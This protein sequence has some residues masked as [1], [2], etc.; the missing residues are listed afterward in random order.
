MAKAARE[1][2]VTPPAVTIQ[3][4]LLEQT[5][6]LPLIERAGERTMQTAAGEKILS[7]ARRIDIILNECAQE[8]GQLKG[9][10]GGRISV[11]VVSTAK[12][13]AP[14]ALAAFRQK[15]N[16]VDV[17]LAVQNRH[18]TLRALESLDIDMAIMGRPPDT[19]N[20]ESEALGAHPHVI[21]ASPEHPLAKTPLTIDG[22][23][24]E[25][26]FVR[27]SGSGTRTVMERFFER[28]GFVPNVG[29][30]IGS[31]ETIK[32]AVIAGLG[33]AF[34]SAHT[35]AAEIAD[36]RLVPLQVEGLPVVRQWFVVR[37]VE[38]KAMP[39]GEAMWQFL[40]K[41]GWRFLPGTLADA[42]SRM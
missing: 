18:A 21:I 1:L 3:L 19:L 35:V 24:N 12:Y 13:F 38:K 34:I 17:R 14:R 20:V 11:G 30:E 33:I 36:G 29:M 9:I 2:N 28:A 25:T 31:N 16:G 23:G 26:F 6:G 41:E 5:V 7:A 37:L 39:A 15:H 42:P 10:R 22:L 40:T 4:Q 32:Q 8:I 27:E